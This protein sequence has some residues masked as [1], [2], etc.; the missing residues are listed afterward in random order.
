MIKFLTSLFIGLLFVSH[1][2]AQFDKSTWY[3]NMSPGLAVGNYKKYVDKNKGQNM[4]FGFS[5]GWLFNTLK[6]QRITSPV[7]IGPEIGFQSYGNYTTPNRVGG[8]FFESHSSWYFNLKLR[9]RPIVNFSK[10]N[11]YFDVAIG[12][13]FYSSKI[14]ERISQDETSILDKYNNFAKNYHIGTGV[15]F[16]LPSKRGTSKYLDFGI[17]YNISE[18]SKRMIFNSS[19]VDSNGFTSFGK[20]LVRENLLMMKVGITGFD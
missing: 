17:Q 4:A 13:K 18:G 16:K 3:I 5:C 1:S 2:Q 11:P 7:F 6:N 12:P 14:H 20:A 19:L 15:G 9:Y 10:L 8:D